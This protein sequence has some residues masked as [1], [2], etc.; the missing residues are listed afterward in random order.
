[1]GSA[2]P[3]DRF[4][5]STQPMQ[6]LPWTASAESC[7]RHHACPYGGA[8][9]AGDSLLCGVYI[10]ARR[11][12][13]PSAWQQRIPHSFPDPLLNG[14]IASPWNS[15]IWKLGWA[16]WLMPVI[17]AL[18]EAK[19]GEL[20]EPRSLRPACTTQKDPVSTKNTKINE[21]WWHAPVVPATLEAER[22][23]SS[24]YRHL[25]SK[26]DGGREDSVTTAQML[27]HSPAI[28]TSCVGGVQERA[29]GNH[30]EKD[31]KGIYSP[32]RCYQTLLTLSGSSFACSWSSSFRRGL[33]H[34]DPLGMCGLKRPF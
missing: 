14:D 6:R 3:P 8:I 26:R 17:L 27:T 16:W 19:V 28:F 1:M 20:L 18:W 21:V 5:R 31:L 32:L 7:D 12:E 25:E 10:L 13:T 24:R 30:S 9:E 4:T 29:A 34:R 33:L 22:R 2:S 15:K 11:P 23:T